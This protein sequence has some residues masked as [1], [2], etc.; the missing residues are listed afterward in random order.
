M[1]A[2]G[3]GQMN[4]SNNP[5]TDHYADYRQ[6]F[7]PDGSKIAFMSD[8]DGN[9]DV[10]IMNADGSGLEN[11]SN[12]PLDESSAVF[13][14]DGGKIAFNS[15]RDGYYNWEVYIM[16][17]DGSGLENLS[18]NAAYDSSCVWG[19]STASD[20]NAVARTAR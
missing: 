5:L 15:N 4:L 10:Y 9:R 16:N 7:S 6:V 14:P 12:S 20:S 18:N 1:N 3:S 2:D 11:L 13:S 19:R 17:A 8:R